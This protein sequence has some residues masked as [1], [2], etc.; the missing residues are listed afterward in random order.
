MRKTKYARQAENYKME[1][2]SLEVKQPWREDDYS[3]P[4]S[5]EVKND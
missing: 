3:P 1:T 2:L 5:V 4:T